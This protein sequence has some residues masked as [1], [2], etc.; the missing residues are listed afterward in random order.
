MTEPTAREI[1]NAAYRKAVADKEAAEY[2]HAEAI[3]SQALEPCCRPFMKLSLL[4]IEDSP[5]T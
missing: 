4:R 5:S 2:R 3:L 1:A